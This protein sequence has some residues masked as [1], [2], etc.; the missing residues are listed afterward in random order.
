[1]SALSTGEKSAS[2]RS[3]MPPYVLLRDF[4]DAATVA[5]LLAY[6]LSRQADFQPTRVGSRAVDPSIRVSTGLRDLDSYRKIL[7]GKILGIVPDLVARLQVI[8]LASPRLETELVAHGDGAFYR[9]HI[10]TQTARYEHIDEIRVLSGVYYFFAEPKAFSGG[11]LRLYAIGGDPNQNFVDIEPQRNSLLVFPS[12]APH[13][14]RPVHCPSGR[15][16]DSRFAV[17][18]WLHRKK[19]ST[20]IFPLPSASR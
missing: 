6:A 19:A 5:E 20:D 3:L 10:D 11:A 9:R 8:P 18:C 4:L 16:I 15:F 13:E 7:K 14:V 12:W 17:N 2:A 1:M